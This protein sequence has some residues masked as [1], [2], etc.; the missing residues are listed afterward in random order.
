MSFRDQADS[1]A[2]GLG[3]ALG[4]KPAQQSISRAVAP[5][6]GRTSPL[7]RIGGSHPPGRRFSYITRALRFNHTDDDMVL[8]VDQVHPVVLRTCPCRKLK[9]V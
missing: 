3:V 5:P 8:V 9:R 1:L 6:D 4:N 7:W 2:A